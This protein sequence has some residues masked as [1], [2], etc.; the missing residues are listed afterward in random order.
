MVGNFAAQVLNNDYSIIVFISFKLKLSFET[1][2][3]KTKENTLLKRISYMALIQYCPMSYDM[4]GW[5][6]R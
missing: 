4:K 2:S 6:F 1:T 3:F 5:V